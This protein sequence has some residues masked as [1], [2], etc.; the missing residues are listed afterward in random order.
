MRFYSGFLKAHDAAW[1]A[2]RALACRRLSMP[3]RKQAC[4]HAYLCSGGTRLFVSSQQRQ[5]ASHGGERNVG[6]AVQHKN[7]KISRIT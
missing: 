6:P 1:A 3:V 2:K 7:L 5:G 4:S